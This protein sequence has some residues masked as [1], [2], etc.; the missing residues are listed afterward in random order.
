MVK[1]TNTKLKSIC[2]PTHVG[3]RSRNQEHILIFVPICN[4]KSL[5]VHVM[6]SSPLSCFLVW[7][8]PLPQQWRVL[9][10]AQTWIKRASNSS[11]ARI[12]KN[13]SSISFSSERL[14]IPHP[15]P[16]VEL[17]QLKIYLLINRHLFIYFFIYYLIGSR[18]EDLKGLITFDVTYTQFFSA[19]VSAV[20]PAHFRKIETRYC[21]NNNGNVFYATNSSILS[22]VKITL[23]FS[24]K[25]TT[26]PQLQAHW[27]PD[28]HPPL[29]LGNM[30]A[31][32]L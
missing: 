25:K 2:T 26:I 12:R 27:N 16:N 5:W 17:L 15:N 9:H 13:E 1:N 32:I 4:L 11:N 20:N 24:F 8:S 30:I 29:Q 23:E 6:S 22:K 10:R 7:W 3:G 14:S 31:F 19:K 21:K 28:L 18:P